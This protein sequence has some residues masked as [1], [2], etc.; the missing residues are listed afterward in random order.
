MIDFCILGSGIAGSTIANLL[1]KN[2]SVRVFDKARGLGGRTSNKRFKSNLSFDHGTQYISPKSKKFE[3]FINKLNDKNIVKVWTGNHLDF[4]FKKKDDQKKFVGKKANNDICKYQLKNIKTNFSSNAIKINYKKKFWEI[5][6]DNNKIYHSKSLIITFPYIQLKKLAKNYL[7][8]KLINLNLKMNPNIT[9]MIATKSSKNIPISSLKLEDKII[10]WVSNEN[11]KNRFKTNLNLWTIQTSLE[12]SKKI[13]DNYKNK[14]SF[15][16]NQILDRFA[17]LTGL[18][19]SQI[20]FKSIHGWKYAYNSSNL[21][22]KSYWN[23]KYNFGA[24][25]DWFRGSKV[26]SAWISS[27]DLLYQIKKNPLKK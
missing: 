4:S 8:K 17:K 10:A 7:N 1:S 12:Y 18:S 24:C 3:L 14:K 15:Y 22:M 21:K 27:E 11:S 9:V 13:I 23:K 2:Y 20:V 26:E 5:T 25:G 19:K 6:F 16:I